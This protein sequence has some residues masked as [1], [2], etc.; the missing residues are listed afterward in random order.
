MVPELGGQELLA[1]WRK[2]MDSFLSSATS[3]GGRTDV[4]RQ[5]LEPMRRQLELVAEL[6]A[7]ERQVQQQVVGQLL[8]PVDAVFDLLDE[9]GEMLR[10]QAQALHSA[11][12]ALDDTA[13]LVG[14]QAELFERALAVLR[15][16]TERAKVLAGV[17]KHTP[18]KK[19]SGKP[20]QRAQRRR[21]PSTRG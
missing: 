7:R 12:R 9:S 6:I 17:D 1:E 2:A 16:P 10:K 21:A 11:S 5:L 20:R 14:T 4:P 19:G 13:K 18:K 3:L 8:A 15:E